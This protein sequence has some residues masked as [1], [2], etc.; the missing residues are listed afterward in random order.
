MVKAVLNGGEI[1][2]LGPLPADWQ[3]GQV[4]LV[5]KAEPNSTR[6]ADID[7]DFA[8]LAG[9]CATSEDPDE[10]QLQRALDEARW[11]AKD[12]VRRQMGIG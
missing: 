12:Q 11:Q 9:L 5:E 2:P 8:L 6:A 3:D 4:L 1:R 10:T 7:G